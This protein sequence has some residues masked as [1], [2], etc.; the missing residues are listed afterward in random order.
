MRYFEDEDYDLIYTGSKLS[1]LHRVAHV[2]TLDS[3][4]EIKT[5]TW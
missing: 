1:S 5:N 3:L 2:L 4:R